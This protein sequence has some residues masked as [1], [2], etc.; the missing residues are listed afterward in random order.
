MRRVGQGLVGR[1]ACCVRACATQH[2]ERAWASHPHSPSPAAARCRSSGHFY[3]NPTN[4][5][6]R[7]LRDTGIAPAASIRGAEDDGRMP[8]VAGVVSLGLDAAGASRRGCVRAM[9]PVP[10]R[11]RPRSRASLAAAGCLALTRAAATHS[12]AHHRA[13]RASPMWAAAAP[14]PTAHSLGP[15]TL[16]LGDPAS[17][18]G[19]RRRRGAPAM[20]WAAPAAA[21]ARLQ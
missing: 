11:P 13:S 5:M 1:A 6:W 9:R 10:R 17:L 4:W 3:S 7:I 18:G 19:W 15:P 8:E 16:L 2:R 21:A 12:L 14:A 20:A